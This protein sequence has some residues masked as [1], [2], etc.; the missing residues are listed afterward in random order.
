MSVASDGTR[1]ADPELVAYLDGGLEPPAH[2]DVEALL[3]VDPA[4]RERLATLAAGGRSLRYAF[5]A[6]LDAAPR[7][8]MQARLAE[9]IGRMQSRKSPPAKR[10]WVRVFACAAAASLLAMVGATGG[11]LAAGGAPPKLLASLLDFDDSDAWLDAVAKQVS[12]YRPQS[13]AQ[14]SLDPVAQDSELARLDRALGLAL[15]AEAV[16]LP[17][18]TLKR[19]ELLQHRQRALAQLL[20][21]SPEAGLLALCIMD[22]QEADESPTAERR[23]GLNLVYWHRGGRAYLL[24]GTVEASQLRN[25]AD[26]LRNRRSL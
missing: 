4:A 11:Y 2:R 21:Y 18:Y 24:L 19:V 6:L 5:D 3:K 8:R 20:Y 7:D 14:I 22:E 9:T 10:S 12:L 23:A 15:S 1:P 25:L 17:G 26:A 16:A 13:V